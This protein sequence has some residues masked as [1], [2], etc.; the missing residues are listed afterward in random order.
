MTPG[1]EAGSV[2]VAVGGLV[3]SGGDTCQ[4]GCRHG[5]PQRFEVG[6][7]LEVHEMGDG[8]Q[9]ESRGL[10]P[11]HEPLESA[12]PPAQRPWAGLPGYVQGW[13]GDLL[14]QVPCKAGEGN[15]GM[16]LKEGSLSG[17]AVPSA[18]RRD[19][20]CGSCCSEAWHR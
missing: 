4:G 12:G 16:W 2:E 19:L 5:G 7:C 1:T 11:N 17:S 10:E 13:K 8:E 3:R 6:L 20:S 15:L 14:S 18:T 9:V